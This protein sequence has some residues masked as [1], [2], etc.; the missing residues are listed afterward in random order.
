MRVGVLRWAV[1]AV[2]C[3]LLAHVPTALAAGTSTPLV[4]TSFGSMVVDDVNQHVFVSSPSVNTIAVY[5]FDGQ[6]V[7]TIPN[8]G[9][10]SG[11]VISGS[12]LYVAESTVGSVEAINL[13]TLAD[14]GPLATGLA[15]P[16]RLVFAAGRLWTTT[17]G[18]DGQSDL[19]TSVT[20]GGGVTVFPTP[21]Y[22]AD[23]ATSPATPNM[24]YVAADGFIPG[25][26]YELNVSS[27][28][29]VVTVKNT[30]TDQYEIN[31]LAV[32][33]NGERVIPAAN[34]PDNF[35][36]LRASTLTADGTTYP[37]ED[38][39]SA[40]AISPAYGGLLATGTYDYTDFSYPQDILVYQLGTSTPLFRASTGEFAN[41]VAHG[42]ALSAD[43]SQVFA[44]TSNYGGNA[45]E[46][47]SL[48]VVG[49]DASGTTTT[50]TAPSSADSGQQVA[51]LA[52]VSPTDGAGYV[53]FES[54]G[55]AIA[56]CASVRLANG[57]A[58]CDTAA[59]SV[60]SNT[61]E[62]EYSGDPLY[63]GSSD[64]TNVSIYSDATAVNVTVT[65]NSL[66][67]D[68]TA[69]ATATAT[70]EDA[71]GNLV[72]GDG[73]SFT[74]VP[75]AV[76]IHT[77][78]NEGTGISTVTFTATT[79]A[80]TPTS[81]T[82][83][84]ADPDSRGDASGSV[85]LTLQRAP[86]LT[87]AG[88][89]S[90]LSWSALQNWA[91]G[92]A[93]SGTVGTLSFPDLTSSAC[94]GG[95]SPDAC[96][97]A[98]ND[99]S[100]LNVGSLDVSSDDGYDI[101]GN[102]ITLRAGG[103]DVSAPSAESDP[104][105]LDLPLLLGAPQSWTIDSGPV[106]LGGGV[107]GDET[108]ALNV[109]AGSIE[110]RAGFEV[111]P[112]SEDG[113]GGFYLDG[114]ES[115]NSTDG[116]AITL[117]NGA[118]IEADQTGN[119]VGPVTLEPSG[120]ISVGGIDDGGGRLDVDGSVTSLTS[121]TQGGLTFS[122]GSTLDLAVDHPGTSAGVDY[123]QLT[124][125]GNIG[126]DQT[127]LD[128]SQG[129]TTEGT[130][131]DLH[132]GDQLTLL[133]TSGGSINGT[134]SNYPEGATVDLG[135]DCNGA[136]RAA[137]GTISYS[138]NA[139]N[140]TI[141]GGGDAGDVPVELTPPSVS[142]TAE[143]GQ[144]LQL[145]PGTWQGSTSLQYSWWECGT[146]TCSQIPG[147]ASST[148][149][150]TS[151]EL[152]DQIAVGVTAV[153]AAGSNTELS[154]ETVP[155]TA[156]PVPV[157]TGVPA[158]TGGT[159]VGETLTASTG[160]WSNSPTGYGYRWQLCSASGTY[161]EPIPGADSGSYTLTANEV[162]STIAVQTYSF[163]YGGTS[164]VSS[165]ATTAVISSP[166]V[167]VTTPT[168][169]TTTGVPKPT[170]VSTTP[171]STVVAA[172]GIPSVSVAAIKAALKLILVPTGIDAEGKKIVQLD[173]YRFTFNS[174]TAGHLSLTWTATIRH[175]TV[176]LAR[177]SVGVSA[178]HAVKFKVALTAQGKR[179]LSRYSRLRIKANADFGVL[180]QAPVSASTSFT[181]AGKTAPSISRRQL[182]T[183]HGSEARAR[184][185]LFKRR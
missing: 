9:G 170:V 2:A 71:H 68:G 56:G 73:I 84:A 19:L 153:G 89:A 126:L 62:A 134:F 130:C 172:S 146:Y 151:A 152:R 8:I 128:V 61:V 20:L 120:W 3:V 72:A 81:V 125:T 30:D 54:D 74:A 184:L 100:G 124:A 148:F 137:S 1:A 140:L 88:A 50:L 150:P 17:T 180:F 160:T 162:G 127:E 32:S 85:T 58:T 139:V 67:A 117:L 136:D 174:L 109:D 171:S 173:G 38:T 123:S 87:W 112:I 91:G 131:V 40:V 142:G 167:A 96:Y 86:S 64:S 108:L 16:T 103:L 144:T 121:V 14:S 66:L 65:P 11:M 135:D 21:Y 82:I 69:T 97:D 26:I 176:T 158:I 15:D 22:G 154:A 164:L 114:N 48:N 70:V 149:V 138:S 133:S 93:P 83:T 55:T 177:A 35:E 116:N 145:A 178:A 37:G 36:E 175:Q 6:L 95:T 113:N 122:G 94:L 147:A 165:S 46:L 132:P 179:D 129:V 185:G 183:L 23:L 18:P 80:N 49:A 57:T 102:G 182:A 115:V 43:G 33:P 141:T 168:T 156:E 76:T 31:Q 78:D 25:S 143:E 101:S 166:A 98:G 28:T 163:N 12:S 157:A 77:V 41:V 119:T 99:I 42:L 52:S 161:C 51:L 105:Q 27:G 118:G 13:A 104:P 47:W 181:L 34:Y 159:G 90:S 4:G 169:V 59:L 155:V 44:V 39:P 92:S 110:P 29:P 10:A 63:A 60:G 107:S 24:L 111:G 7:T 53:T 5:D 75:S 45:F 106:V 79:D